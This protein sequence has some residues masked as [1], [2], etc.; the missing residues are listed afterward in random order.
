M[1]TQ[2]H[3]PSVSLGKPS[4]R[5]RLESYYSLIAPDAI[6]DKEDWKRKFEIIYNKFGGSVEGETRLANK[7]SKKY[8]NQVSF[9]GLLLFVK[10]ANYCTHA[11]TISTT[12]IR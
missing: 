11:N 4:L 10:R 6:A 5:H 7:L 3:A 9:N 12:A 1:S 2:S 8:G